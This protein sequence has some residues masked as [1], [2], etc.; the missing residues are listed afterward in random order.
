MTLKKILTNWR[1]LVLIFF[2]L[3]ALVAL[4]PNPFNEGVVIHS[5]AKNSTASLAGIENPQPKAMPMTREKIETINNV[6][7]T[8]QQEY[9]EFFENTQANRTVQVKTTKGIYRVQVPETKEIGLRID[10]APTTN[11]RKGLDIQGGTRV[12]LK[13]VE[14]VSQQT[15]TDI[16]DLLKERLNVYG[17]SDLAVTTVSDTPGFLGGTPSF[18]LVEIS[19]ATEEEVRDLMSKQGKFESKI[20]NQTV[21]KGN[22]VT[23]VCRTAE[24]SGIDPNSPCKQSTEGWNCGFYFSI[25]ISQEAAK[26]MAE[27]TKDIPVQEESLKEQIAFYLDD[28]EASR[29]NIAAD[30]KGRAV[31]DIAISGAGFGTTEYSAIDDT[32]L[33]MKKLQTILLT[34][35]LPVKLEVVKIDNI[36]PVLGDVFLKNALF[37]GLIAVLAVTLVLLVAYRSIRIGLAIMFTALSEIFLVLGLAAL[38]GWSIDL[39]AIAGLIITVGTG[40]NDQ[41]VITDEAVN[42]QQEYLRSWKERLKRAF[43]IIFSAY[44]TLTVAMIPLLFAGAGL[45]KGFAITTIL[46]VTMGVFVTRPAFAVLVEYIVG[47]D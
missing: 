21:F 11:L 31:T 35:S 18:I 2:Y 27:A 46:G 3:A 19:G 4:K 33:E 36:S 37:V 28:N 17:L 42:R 39:A 29:L 25:T 16:A 47:K 14:E 13:P 24:C 30:L 5:V 8:N 43:F 23:Y 41:I 34:G 7:I 20:A 6:P 22:E 45:L 10:D 32:L 38:I 15:L 1:I 40:V 9:Y 12:L 44:F 26:K